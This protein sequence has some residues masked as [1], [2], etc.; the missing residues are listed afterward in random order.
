MIFYLLLLLALIAYYLLIGMSPWQ[1]FYIPNPSTVFPYG[2]EAKVLLGAGVAFSFVGLTAWVSQRFLWARRLNEE[3]APIFR[4]QSNME[5][6]GLALSSA[7]VEEVIFRGWLQ[8]EYGILLSATI[9]GT[10]HVPLKLSHIPW[11]I[12]ALLMGFVFAWMFQYTG[13]LTA[14]FI[15]HFSI[16]Y[17]NIHALK[18]Q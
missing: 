8:Q 4:H 11:T 15:A 2:V 1:L 17:F 6:T 9:F 12:S 14:V 3:F 13:D 10:L 5:I 18:K 7:L 16:N